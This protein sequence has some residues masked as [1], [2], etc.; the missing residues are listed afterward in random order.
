M[1]ELI[2]KLLAMTDYREFEAG[3]RLTGLT[4][5][6]SVPWQAPTGMMVDAGG[7][8][9]RPATEPWRLPHSYTPQAVRN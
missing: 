9:W 7:G 6:G 5:H 4:E 2:D 8:E 1:P 3:M